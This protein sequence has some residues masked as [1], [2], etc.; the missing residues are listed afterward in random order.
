[1]RATLDIPKIKG[2]VIFTILPVVRDTSLGISYRCTARTVKK[3]LPKVTQRKGLG[4][5]FTGYVY[6][7]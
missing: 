4:F 7:C 5:M 3:L 1:L 6:N 2:K